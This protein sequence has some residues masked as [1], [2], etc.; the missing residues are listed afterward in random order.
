MIELLFF[1][2]GMM[3]FFFP[4]EMLFNRIWQI[5]NKECG[6]CGTRKNL[7]IDVYRHGGVFFD[8]ILPIKWLCNYHYR[9]DRKITTDDF[10]TWLDISK[11]NKIPSPTL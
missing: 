11:K 5:R 6:V 4:F 10:T 7:I 3:F 8:C 2:S 1:I 9:K